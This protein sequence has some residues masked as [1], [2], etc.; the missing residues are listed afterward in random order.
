MSI[1]VVPAS[2]DDPG[3]VDLL[4]THLATM[5]AVTPAGFVFALDLNGLRGDGVRLFALRDGGEL[6]GC[7][8]IARIDDRHGELKSMHVRAA[9]RGEGLAGRLLASLEADARARGVT[10]LS[11]ETGDTD[12][13]AAARALYTRHGY[14]PCGPFGS[15]TDN[16][17]SA[18]F[19]KA[20]HGSSDR[21]LD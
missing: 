20:L 3:M 18:Y 16:G 12:E 6:I 19:T 2:V 17:H 4:E 14:A 7:G 8:A 15:Y 1:E 5:H 9:R 13:F 11:L 10:R 21:R